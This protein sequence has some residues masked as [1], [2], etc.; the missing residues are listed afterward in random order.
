MKA[1]PPSGRT[2]ARK[3][4]AKASGFPAGFQAAAAE[5]VTTSSRL[6]P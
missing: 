4:G 2:P 5:S 6:S 1:I 3:R